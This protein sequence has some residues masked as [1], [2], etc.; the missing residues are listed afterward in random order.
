MF[1]DKLQ[2][3]LVT[4]NAI[5]RQSFSGQPETRMGNTDQL[6]HAGGLIHTVIPVFRDH[7]TNILREVT[8]PAPC[9]SIVT[10]RLTTVPSRTLPY[11]ARQ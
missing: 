9:L 6:C 5:R 4:Y 7:V 1:R 2:L 10:I 3:K 11:W 8:T